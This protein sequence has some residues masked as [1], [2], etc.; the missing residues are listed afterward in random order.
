MKIYASASVIAGTL[1][2]KHTFSRASNAMIDARK[3]YLC[4]VVFAPEERIVAT[5]T[6]RSPRD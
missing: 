4:V 3:K 6:K 5:S 2:R 1:A